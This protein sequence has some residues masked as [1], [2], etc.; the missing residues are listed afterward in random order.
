M[1]MKQ[2]FKSL[3]FVLLAVIA[4]TTAC[5]K[6]ENSSGGESALT[7]ASCWKITK[8]EGQAPGTT[9]WVDATSSIDACVRDNCIKFNSDKTVDG[10]EGATKCDPSDP[11]E[12]DGGTWELSADGKTL[13]LTEGVDVTTSTVVE[14][15]SSKLV[16][17]T[18]ES[19]VKVRITWTN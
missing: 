12:F 8:A 15:S 13:T 9:T 16:L 14:L 19:G 4:G 6:D 3:L 5:K 18:T 11:Q 1:H 10:N 17:E 2:T 7:A